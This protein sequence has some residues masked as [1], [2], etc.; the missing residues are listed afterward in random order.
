[1]A[2]LTPSLVVEDIDVSTGHQLAEAFVFKGNLY[3][4]D[5]AIF[6][7]LKHGLRTEEVNSNATNYGD[8]AVYN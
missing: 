2:S 3:V 4:R 6:E 7:L 5:T 1:M 8:R